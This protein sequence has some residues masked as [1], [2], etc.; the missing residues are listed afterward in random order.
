MFG[1]YY[2]QTNIS[3]FKGGATGL[4]FSVDGQNYNVSATNIAGTGENLLYAGA[5]A[6]LGMLN[7]KYTGMNIDDVFTSHFFKVDTLL[8]FDDIKIKPYIQYSITDLDSTFKNNMSIKDDDISLLKLGFNISKD[9][10]SL[11]Y[12]FGKTGKNGSG[13]IHRQSESSIFYWTSSPENYYDA[14]FHAGNISMQV[15]PKLKL[16]LYAI[17]IDTKQDEKVI[18][19]NKTDASDET[20]VFLQSVY[21]MSKNFK[22]FV[23]VGQ[24]DNEFYTDKSNQFR[25]DIV[26]N[27]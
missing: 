23:N 6:K 8:K 16:S 9:I 15:F 4:G 25:T 10:Y 27:F 11:A 21:S 1:G 3:D 26:Y 24:H 22:I 14:I 13:I 20:L 2:N 18:L 19:D 5:V 7:A 12:H 17:S